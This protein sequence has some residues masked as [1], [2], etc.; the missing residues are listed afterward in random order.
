MRV[1]ILVFSSVL[2]ITGLVYGGIINSYG[3]KV[4][5]NFAY[6]A[7][8]PVDMKVLDKQYK[9]M[10][11]NI[12]VFIEFVDNDYFNIITELHFKRLRPYEFYDGMGLQRDDDWE[13]HGRKWELKSI[14]YLSMPVFLMKF[15][16]PVGIIRPYGYFGPRFDIFLN[17]DCYDINGKI[18][19]TGKEFGYGA[20]GF[21]FGFGFEWRVNDSFYISPES[22]LSFDKTES[23]GIYHIFGG[24]NRAYVVM[25]GVG[26]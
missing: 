17:A 22:K 26:F 25:V 9:N 18:E 19:N 5:I 15:S 3:V 21:D 4:G 7:F 14:D 20:F 1:I 16:Y 13:E 10:G 2:I 11:F 12:G 23:K 8:P 6:R 24:K